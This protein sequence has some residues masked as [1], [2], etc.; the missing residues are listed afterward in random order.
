MTYLIF[1]GFNTCFIRSSN[2]LAGMDGTLG[3]ALA[4]H[5]T[6]NLLH[7]SSRNNLWQRPFA[8]FLRVREKEEPFRARRHML[9]ANVRFSVHTHVRTWMSI[10]VRKHYKD[11]NRLED[12]AHRTFSKFQNFSPFAAAATTTTTTTTT[13]T[14]TSTITITII[15]IIIILILIIIIIIILIIIILILILIIIIIIIIAI[16]PLSSFLLLTSS[17]NNNI[18]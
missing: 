14:S 3:A 18:R 8:D 12:H 7:G 10:T 4:T 9:R 6:R 13:T 5:T 16:S 11:C 2:G 17:A 1:Q 15:I